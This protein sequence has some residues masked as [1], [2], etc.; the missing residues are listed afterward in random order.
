MSY[1]TILLQRKI[2]RYLFSSLCS[3]FSIFKRDSGINKSSK[4][5]DKNKIKKILVIKL[6]ALGDSVVL[7]PTLAALKKQFPNAELHVLAH[8]RNKVVFEG[9]PFVDKI[10]DFGVLN[11]LKLFRKYDIC[12][13]SEPALNVSAVISFLASKNTVGFSHGTRAKLY[14]K[15]SLFNKTRHMV[16]NYLDLARKIGVKYNT[17]R[18][19]PIAVSEKE[20]YFVNEYFK[21]NKL[22]KNNFVVC[23]APGVAES[24]KFRMWPIE[25]FAKLADELVKKYNAKIILVDTKMNEN[26]IN[27]I[28]SLM[29]EKSINAV[30]EF[31]S[32]NKIKM[33]AELMKRCNVVI[34]ND[35]GPMHISAAMGTKTLG[36]FG[37]NT[38]KLW[39]PYGKHNISIFKPKKGCPF[40]N[41][42]NPELMPRKLTHEQETCMD[43]ITV[44]DV[45][46]AVVRIK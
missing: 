6:W 45:I 13:D 46:K 24:V 18:L 41:N 11:V 38:P 8:R 5:P 3:F 7:L 4:V 22:S 10:I 20:K 44:E 36:L 37:P 30:P 39:A 28:Q 16:Q 9:Q 31:G 15:T 35:S 23:I 32:F 14:S 2:D 19:I 17:D 42:K 27:K 40:M 33:T 26:I 1:L 29:L 25:N 12:I 43:A 21:K 34:S